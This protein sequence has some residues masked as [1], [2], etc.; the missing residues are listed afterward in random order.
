MTIN[1][2]NASLIF[3]KIKNIYVDMSILD[4]MPDDCKD[5]AVVELCGKQYNVFK[6]A[7]L[8]LEKIDGD[9][10]EIVECGKVLFIKTGDK[11]LYNPDI[12]VQAE[13]LEQKRD[14][15]I[16]VYKKRRRKD[17]R[18]KQGHRQSITIIKVISC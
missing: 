2:N 4:S 10:G 3:N 5:H 7:V 17:Y 11:V 9:V 1:K 18:K 14:K 16:V 12:T 15:K 13:I 6:G 8:A